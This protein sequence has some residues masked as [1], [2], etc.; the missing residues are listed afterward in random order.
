MR[1]RRVGYSGGFVEHYLL[2]VMYPKALTLGVQVAEGILV[3]VVNPALY[4][5]VCRA[6]SRG[7]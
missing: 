7:T 3:L 6:R 5:W 2:P 1:A 4:V